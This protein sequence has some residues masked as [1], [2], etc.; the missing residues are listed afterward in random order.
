MILGI[1]GSSRRQPH[2]QSSTKYNLVDQSFD[3]TEEFEIESNS[4]ASAD[5][6]PS[7]PNKNFNSRSIKSNIIIRMNVLRSTPLL[8]RRSK[9]NSLKSCDS[10]E[11]SNSGGPSGNY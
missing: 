8:G 11:S 4:S 7:S 5:E 3:E 6:E 10:T 2:L 9:L 1:D